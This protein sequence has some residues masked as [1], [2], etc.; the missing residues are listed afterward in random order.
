MGISLPPSEVFLNIKQTSYIVNR[1]INEIDKYYCD[2]PDVLIIGVLDGAKKL[3]NN[4]YSELYTKQHLASK[5]NISY[6][7]AKSYYDKTIS[8]GEVEIDLL[9][10]GDIMGREILL[11]DDIY[12]TGYT[13]STV[14]E[15]LDS[16]QPNNINTCVLIDRING[17]KKDVRIDFKGIDIKKR[18]GQQEAFIRWDQLAKIGKGS[19]KNKNDFKLF[20]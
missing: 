14:L 3:S 17:H 4:I 6:I 15:K 19:L 20:D 8:S 9:D 16:F 13:L 7:K 11:V 1:L 2:I 10:L 18:G 12:D 5:F